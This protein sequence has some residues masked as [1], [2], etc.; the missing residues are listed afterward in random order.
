ATKPLMVCLSHRRLFSKTKRV[1]T[2]WWLVM[3][4]WCLV[5]TLNSVRPTV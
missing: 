3:I 1:T 5:V 4:T 2:S